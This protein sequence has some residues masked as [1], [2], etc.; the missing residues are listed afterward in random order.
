M[1]VAAYHRTEDLFAIP[2]QIL[3]IC[4]DYKLYLRKDACL[5][6]WGVNYIFQR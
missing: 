5:P 4:P 6:A 2:H 3:Q 1:L